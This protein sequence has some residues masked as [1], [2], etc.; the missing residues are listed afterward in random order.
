M[1]EWFRALDLKYGGSLFKSFTLP[2]SEFILGTPEVKSSTALCKK[3]T[4]EPPT[5][6]DS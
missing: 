2:L 1:V 4:G 3:P 6:W 5:S